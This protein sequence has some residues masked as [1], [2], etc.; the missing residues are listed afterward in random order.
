MRT[1]KE[2]NKIIEEKQKEIEALKKEAEQA[3][4]IQPKYILADKL[5]GCLCHHNH[6]D[7]CGWFYEKSWDDPWGREYSAHNT[8]LE[9]AEAV[10]KAAGTDDIDY[11][12]GIVRAIN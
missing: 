8:Y 5:H 4:T 6:T 12:M 3:K 2:I 10:I 7:G 9:K 11:I 1:E